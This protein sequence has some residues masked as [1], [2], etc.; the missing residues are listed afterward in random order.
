MDLLTWWKLTNGGKICETFWI[1]HIWFVVL[2]KKKIILLA[3]SRWKGYLRL[4]LF[5]IF[6]A[7][8]CVCVSIFVSWQGW[9][10]EL[11]IGD[12]FDTGLA[13]LFPSSLT[14]T[15]QDSCHDSHPF[16]AF[17]AHDA[18]YSKSMNKK[19]ALFST[20]LS[21][22]ILNFYNIFM[23]CR[24]SMLELQNTMYASWCITTQKL[25]LYIW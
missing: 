10:Q 17:S 3:A 9:Q 16:T 19:K 25:Y 8:V 22:G 4:L 7:R 15:R 13:V 14:L 24:N 2:K 18:N 11:K 20:I 5:S 23:H 12:P 1:C 6:C 21:V